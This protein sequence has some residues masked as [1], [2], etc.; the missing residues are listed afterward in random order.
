[1]AYYGLS[2]SNHD[3]FNH[4]QN[5]GFGY[6]QNK[7]PLPLNFE[8]AIQEL[9]NSYAESLISSFKS[10]EFNIRNSKSQNS[11]NEG[12]VKTYDNRKVAPEIK[13]MLQFE[14]KRFII[15]NLKVIQY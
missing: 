2:I 15:R 9:V 7:G 11:D 1:M 5:Y 14:F 4:Y 8:P 10:K 3:Y 13:N 12:L 6:H